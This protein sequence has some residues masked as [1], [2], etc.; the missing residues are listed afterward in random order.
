MHWPVAGTIQGYQQ[1]H[2]FRIV[3]WNSNMWAQSAVA[4]SQDQRRN[5]AYPKDNRFALK[6]FLGC[7]LAPT[8]TVEHAPAAFTRRR[9]AKAPYHN[10]MWN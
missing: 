10:A 1:T 9:D 3:H 5:Q 6:R 2:S 7:P 8:R 4:P